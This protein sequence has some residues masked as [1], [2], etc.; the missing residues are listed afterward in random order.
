M[1]VSTCPMRL[2]YVWGHVSQTH[3]DTHMHQNAKWY[4]ILRVIKITQTKMATA[5]RILKRAASCPA[6]RCLQK[7]GTEY[8]GIIFYRQL[9]EPGRCSCAGQSIGRWKALLEPTHLLTHCSA[10]VCWI[11]I[12]DAKVCLSNIRNILKRLFLCMCF[13]GQEHDK[14][15]ARSM[16]GIVGTGAPAHLLLC[17]CMLMLRIHVLFMPFFWVFF[18]KHT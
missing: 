1:C 9:S 16:E 18:R 3:T 8:F 5:I 12:A 17:K 2:S 14:G 11:S 6:Q 7:T 10:S 13:K 4:N 15:T